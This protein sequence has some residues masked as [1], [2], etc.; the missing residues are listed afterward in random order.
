MLCLG[1][2]SRCHSDLFAQLW[3]T[4]A[5]QEDAQF[6]CS[7]CVCVCVC[8]ALD[9]INVTCECT[10]INNCKNGKFESPNFVVCYK[11][12]TLRIIILF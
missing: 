8:D 10:K 7:V 2:E 9:V 1:V 12:F 6:F 5:D 11:Q 3:L 4:V